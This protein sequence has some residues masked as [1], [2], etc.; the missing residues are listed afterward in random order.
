MIGVWTIS[1]ERAGDGCECVTECTS[2]LRALETAS[3][4]YCLGSNR[5]FFFFFWC[6]LLAFWSSSIGIL[7]TLFPSGLFV[8]C[9]LFIYCEAESFVEF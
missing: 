8:L 5:F 7:S 9:F 2:Y 3:W 4:W 1:L 6:L